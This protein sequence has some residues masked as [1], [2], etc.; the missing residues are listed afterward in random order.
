MQEELELAYMAGLI[1]GEGHIGV[2]RVV[3]P[4]DT[5]IQYTARISLRMTDESVIR[6][7]ANLFGRSVRAEGVYGPLS[8]RSL[9]NVEVSGKP[10]V[11]VLTALLPHLRVKDRQ[12]RACL[13][14]E[15][16]KAGPGKRTRQTGEADYRMTDGR[17]ITRKTFS[18]G[19]EIMDE[20]ERI[21]QEV[22]L[23]NRPPVEE[24]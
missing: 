9:F 13:R 4:H 23:L 7:F 2:K 10:A 6:D 20:M 11:P 17:I 21:Y 18:I 14:V 8:K 22:K 5:G 3:R 19:Q 12:A 1:D 24:K 16:L 15:E